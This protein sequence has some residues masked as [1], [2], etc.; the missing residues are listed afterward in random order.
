MRRR[1]LGEKE[2][3]APPSFAHTTEV[4]LFTSVPSMLMH[5]HEHK[6]YYNVTKEN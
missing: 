2:W 6:H 1:I 3:V 4:L 5:V